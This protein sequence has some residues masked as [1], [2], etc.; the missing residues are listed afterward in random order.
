MNLKGIFFKETEAPVQAKPAVAK[1]STYPTSVPVAPVISSASAA[2]VPDFAKHFDDVL[3]AA[4]IAGMDFYE[5]MQSL[6]SLSTAAIPEQQKYSSTLAVFKANKIVPQ[7]LID[8]AQHYIDAIEQ[9]KTTFAKQLED[10]KTTKVD[11]R[12][13]KIT[14]LQAENTKLND[15]IQQNTAQIATLQQEAVQRANSIDANRNAFTNAAA[16]ILEKVN[17]IVN[18]IKKYTTNAA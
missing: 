8:T 1:P 4:N 16:V 17:T 3:E 13:Q 12:Y 5:F 14:A 15:Q 9:E 7:T 18:N 11:A 6:D 10:A 2:D